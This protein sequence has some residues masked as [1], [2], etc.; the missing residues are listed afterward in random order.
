[1]AEENSLGLLDNEATQVLTQQLIS[2]LENSN[3]HT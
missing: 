2:L 3:K 1:M